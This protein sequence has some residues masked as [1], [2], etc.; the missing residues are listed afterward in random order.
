M[1]TKKLSLDNLMNKVAPL[2]KVYNWKKDVT[3]KDI[4]LHQKESY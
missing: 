4:E 1:K 2:P 3:K